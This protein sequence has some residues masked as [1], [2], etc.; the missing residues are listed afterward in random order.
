M[1]CKLGF[2]GLMLLD[3]RNILMCESSETT[4]NSYIMLLNKYANA[5][6]VHVESSSQL[7]RLG[8]AS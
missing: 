8:V 3:V 6:S 5:F 7:T 2:M 1:F 4:V